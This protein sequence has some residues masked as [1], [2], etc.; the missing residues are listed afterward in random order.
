[1]YHIL[2]TIFLVQATFIPHPIMRADVLDKGG[3]QRCRGLSLTK[4]ALLNADHVPTL[5]AGQRRAKSKRFPEAINQYQ[6]ISQMNPSDSEAGK[7]CRALFM[8]WK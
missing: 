1:M 2:L 6:R 8:G 3:Y 5:C 4:S 7:A